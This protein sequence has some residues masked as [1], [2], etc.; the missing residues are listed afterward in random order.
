MSNLERKD[1][2]IWG[3]QKIAPGEERNL[4]LVLGERVAGGRLAIPVRVRRALQPGP[5]VFVTAAIHGD[6]ING[7]GAIRNLIL[8][9]P[10]DLLCGSIVLVPVV[11]LLG[12]ELQ[13]RD[14]PDRRDL[15]RSF[16]GS[17]RGSLA[18]RTAAIV[19]D[20][21]VTRC[22][23]GIDLH[24]A[25]RHRSNFPNLRADMQ[26]PA[27]AELAKSFGCEIIVDN[28]GPEGAFRREACA[29]GCPTV[30]LEAGGVGKVESAVVEYAL[31]GIRNVLCALGMVAGEPRQ[32]PYQVVV[33][34]TTWVRAGAGGFLQ[35]HV[36]PGQT[37]NAGEPLATCTSLLGEPIEVLEAPR[38]GIVLGMTTLPAVVPGAAVCHLGTPERGVLKRMNRTI[39]ALADDHLHER[40]KDDLSRNLDVSEV[41]ALDLEEDAEE[42]MAT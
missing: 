27:V 22:D 23:Y 14:L 6:E 33:K 26:D 9:R 13:T 36:S 7:T 20:A 19:F 15:N 2:G 35:F 32:P 16:P 29:A 21:L 39:D 11:N 8:E 41:G 30:L 31:G 4:E 25:A 5:A 28:L 17:A 18:A 42:D 40:V 37:V 38:R 1:V 3:Q 24:S 34:R 10:F 12:F